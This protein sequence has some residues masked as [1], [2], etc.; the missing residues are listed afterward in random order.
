MQLSDV[1]DW[2]EWTFQEE[3]NSLE[4]FNLRGTAHDDSCLVG[5]TKLVHST[6][7]QDCV[8]SAWNGT[9]VTREWSTAAAQFG[10][11]RECA[12]LPR[13]K[14]LPSRKVCGQDPRLLLL[15]FF[16]LRRGFQR[17]IQTR[18]QEEE[19]A[20][21]QLPSTMLITRLPAPPCSRRLSPTSV[22]LATAWKAHLMG[23]RASRQRVV[24]RQVDPWQCLPLLAAARRPLVRRSPA[25]SRRLHR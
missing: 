24:L 5:V 23:T 10:L 3:T 13:C 9:V 20:A 22:I 21:C 25:E 17:G 4:Q 15:L 11:L 8:L 2:S 16:W 7:K 6:L 14:C 1:G 18:L 19:F 12:G